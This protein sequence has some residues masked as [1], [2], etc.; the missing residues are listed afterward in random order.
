MYPLVNTC[1]AAFVND[2]FIC[3]HI[4]VQVKYV[5][6]RAG[7]TA[8]VSL[9]QPSSTRCYLAYSSLSLVPVHSI[10]ALPFLLLPE[11]RTPGGGFCGSVP[12]GN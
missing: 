6:C 4:S 3:V 1:V 2:K 5:S 10:I 12:T 9:G 8:R 11:R 7:P